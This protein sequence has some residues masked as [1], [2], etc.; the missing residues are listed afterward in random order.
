MKGA[1][2][3]TSWCSDEAVEAQGICRGKPQIGK[4]EPWPFFG[5]TRLGFQQVGNSKPRAQRGAMAS[6]KQIEFLSRLVA[7][8]AC[9]LV[10]DV[11]SDPGRPQPFAFEI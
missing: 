9:D 5:C 4:R 7:E 11:S 6:V 10:L 3:A 2:S 8:A 1:R